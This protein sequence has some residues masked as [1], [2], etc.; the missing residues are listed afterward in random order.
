[1][2][3]VIQILP[4][5]LA[6][7]IAA[8]EVIQRPASAIKELIENAVDAKATEIK[9]II[10]DGGKNFIQVSDNGMGMSETDARVCFERHATSKLKTSED[11]F[12]IQ[13]KGFRGEALASIAAVAKVN[14]KT[15]RIEDTIG[16]QIT[17]DASV[18]TDQEPCNCPTGSIFTIKNLF[19]NI[20]A[21]R[22][23]LKSDTVEMRHILDEFQR[24][25]LAHP[26]ITF[27]F[28]N[29]ENL[30]FYLESGSL[31]QRIV[32]ILGSNFNDKLVPIDEE[33]DFV[34][35]TGFVVKPEFAKKTRGDQF[36]F[37][38]D[39]FIKSTYFHHAISGAFEDLMDR[40][41]HPGY[42]IY[43]YLNPSR[44]DVNIHPTKTEV[45]FED[46]RFIY[47][48]M[49]SCIRQALGK[50]HITPTLDFE[51]ESHISETMKKNI[52]DVPE[53]KVSF[54]PLYNPFKTE[55]S[56]L[57]RNQ[58]ESFYEIL[59][60]EKSEKTNTN[61]LHQFVNVETGEI[62]SS[63]TNPML[64]GLAVDEH[65]QLFQL[66]NRYIVVGTKQQLFI[67]DQ[68]RAHERIT[69]EKLIV[70]SDAEKANSQ[71]ALFPDTMDLSPSDMVTFDLI[72]DDLLLMGFDVDT[73][74][75]QS[76]VIRGVP[77]DAIN[78][79]GKFLIENL[80]EQCKNSGS[81]TLSDRRDIVAKNLASRMA[82]RS[83][84]I[85]NKPEMLQLVKDL[86]ACDM[87]WAG[88]NGKPTIHTHT[89]DELDLM[90]DK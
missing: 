45:K 67:I 59:K 39:R 34:K 71:L 17:V 68:H 53:P 6:N 79:D 26:T 10:K 5:S 29:D 23:F 9:L 28:Y 41:A 27:S 14:L 36:L 73:I 32:Q 47:A 88:I 35:I 52:A 13:T 2:S 70:S 12:N 46:E 24:I 20:P 57:N 16:T 69:Y 77:V 58:W 40:D 50:Y 82:I 15:K 25:A 89:G 87:P 61:P 60:S 3:D 49:R 4:D 78:L 44:I 31:R 30:I 38:N 21:R 65:Y 54:N 56:K 90:F 66:F 62:V 83:G 63:T 19:Y 7:Q 80:L 81:L 75:K 42:F 33:T 22:K 51:V 86:F 74:G 84:V 43:M 76:I 11:L 18:V 85:L 48:V 55:Q 72:K 37:V 1:M 8:G 64:E